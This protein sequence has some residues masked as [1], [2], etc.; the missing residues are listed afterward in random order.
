MGMYTG[1]QKS[2]FMFHTFNLCCLL[3]CTLGIK[4]LYFEFYRSILVKLATLQQLML[5]QVRKA[6]VWLVDFGCRNF[7]FG[8][9]ESYTVGG[10]REGV[11]VFS[12]L[13]N[14]L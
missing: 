13:V 12:L 6:D 5:T 2:S 3:N 1:S 11:V 7:C 4:N 9:E 14:W 8:L 10:R